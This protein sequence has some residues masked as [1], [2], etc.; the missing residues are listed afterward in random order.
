MHYSETG[1]QSV[2]SHAPAIGSPSSSVN[3]RRRDSACSRS[4]EAI[5]ARAV[6]FY[7]V[8]ALRT[9]RAQSERQVNG[10]RKAQWDFNRGEVIEG[11]CSIDC[12][13]LH[14]DKPHHQ[15][16][17]KRKSEESVLTAS[18]QLL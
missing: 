13:S 1:G 12:S 10:V 8:G 5:D 2:P 16:A 9:S 7:C 3:L 17:E 18:G 4:Q 11:A 6:L 14:L 15:R